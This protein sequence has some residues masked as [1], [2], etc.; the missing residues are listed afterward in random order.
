MPMPRHVP[1]YSTMIEVR[2][3]CRLHFGLLALDPDQ[4]RQFGGTGLMIKAPDIAVAL[5]PESTFCATGPRCDQAVIF[6]RRFAQSA[7]DAGITPP[8][9][10][11]A[12]RV[13]RCPRAHAGLGTGTQLAMA[14]G[15]AMAAC[16]CPDEIG[17]SRIAAMVGRGARS[18]IGAHGFASGGFIV[19]GGKRCADDLSPCLMR[20]AFPEAWHLV[21]IMPRA[22]EGISGKREF[23]AF[24]RI[25]PIARSETAELCRQVLLGLAPALHEADFQGFSETLY[26]LQQR[27]GRCFASVQGGVYAD[28]QL[29]AI[30]NFIRQ[31]G[32]R[33]VGQSS[34]GPTLYALCQDPEGAE[35]LADVL[36]THFTLDASEVT[37]TAPD[38]QGRQVLQ[39]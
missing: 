17:A 20:I 1:Q 13:T 12:I 21:L 31:R 33:G 28:P 23:A 27:V 35:A 36:R 25:G 26:E 18:A 14:V 6:A 4:E 9:A 24:D 37:V 34:W 30:V 29:E 16:F 32:V 7:L 38:N 8:I 2:T 22:L 19:E 3:P 39:N 10:G 11:A 5:R 15:Q